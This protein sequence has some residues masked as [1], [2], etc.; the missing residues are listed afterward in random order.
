MRNDTDHLAVADHFLEVVLNGLLA[1]IISP[2]PG[3]LRES[4]LLALVPV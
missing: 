2:F 3:R 1:E 4:L